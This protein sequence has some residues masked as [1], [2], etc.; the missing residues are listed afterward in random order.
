GA[1]PGSGYGQLNVTG[2]VTLSGFANLDLSMS[3]GFTPS[4]GQ[5]FVLIDND[6]SDPVTGTFNGLPEGTLVTLNGVQFQLSYQGGDGNDGVLICTLVPR[7]WTGAVNGL[8]SEAGNWIGGVPQA[9][10]P[11][12]FPGGGAA[13]RNMTNDLAL[14]TAFASLVFFDVGYELGGNG[15][16]LT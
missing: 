5:V 1:A 9:G 12:I 3:S 14:G 8:W 2:T 16:T 6:G 7:T 4:L 10:D 11:L 13:N 15:L